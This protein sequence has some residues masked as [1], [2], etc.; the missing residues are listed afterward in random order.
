MFNKYIFY[1]LILIFYSTCSSANIKIKYKIGDEIVTNF[2]I[3][4]ER[5]YLVFLRPNLSRLTQKELLRIS[6]NSLIREIIKKRELDKIYKN[7]KETKFVEDIK[8]KLFLFKNVK[9][10]AEFITL[11]KQNNIEYE[12]IIEKMKYE[13]LWNE[14]ISI[15]YKSLVRI[16]RSNLKKKLK[17]QK[18]KNK[19]FE[20]ELYEI[21]FEV[22]NS[23]DLKERYK[24]ILEFIK[25]NGFKSAASK[26]SI[27]NSSNK[28]GDI[29]WIKETFLSDEIAKLLGQMKEGGITKP[30]K[31]P[32]GY[33]LLKINKK[34]EMEQISNL[35]KE[36]DELVKFEIN[37]QLTQ[38]S[39]LYFKKLK[40]N[41]IINEY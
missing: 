5:N 3:I 11:L 37:K 16:N 24:N 29:G 25:L 23:K 1:F 33:L 8:K 30:I 7:L 38:F 35:D 2:D 41:T 14:L 15:K 28:G 21:L 32:N 12:K 27:S 40:Q 4:N 19:K 34:K 36:L 20:Y 9:N 31:Y 6:E 18:S 22:R 26:F 39:L 10:E 17:M 13:A